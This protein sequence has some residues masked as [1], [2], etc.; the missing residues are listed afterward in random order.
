MNLLLPGIVLV[1]VDVQEDFF[2]FQEDYSIIVQ[3][4]SCVQLFATPG[5]AA[6]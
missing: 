4:L 5:T 2:P 6:H 1:A 3:L